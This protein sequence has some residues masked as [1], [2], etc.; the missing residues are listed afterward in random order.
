MT[1][2]KLCDEVSHYKSE[3]LPSFLAEPHRNN[4]LGTWVRRTYSN[5]EH[6]F[7]CGVVTYLR[8]LD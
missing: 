4:D 3:P 7:F 8:D 6:S 1:K 5:I 2:Q